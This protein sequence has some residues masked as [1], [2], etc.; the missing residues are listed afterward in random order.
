[1]FNFS[2]SLCGILISAM[3]AWTIYLLTIDFY[4][5]VLGMRSSMYPVSLSFPPSWLNIH[6]LISLNILTLSIIA[7]SA[8]LSQIKVPF[9]AEKS[10][11]DGSKLEK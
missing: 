10:I 2:R 7:L 5:I 1:M 11:I 8:A 9:F 3:I 4:S 6:Y